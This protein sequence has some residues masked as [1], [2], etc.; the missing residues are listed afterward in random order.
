MIIEKILPAKN[1]P[2]KF[3]ERGSSWPPIK[4]GNQKGGGK[5][6]KWRAEKRHGYYDFVFLK[7]KFK[8][9]N[10]FRYISIHLTFVD[11]GEN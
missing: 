7:H 3:F 2:P 6:L 8:L 10:L 11:S 4:G 9:L 1:R 5:F